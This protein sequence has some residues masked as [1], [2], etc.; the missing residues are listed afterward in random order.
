MW[1]LCKISRRR[2][3]G[4]AE[5]DLIIS[6][7]LESR[8]VTT[9]QVSV[10]DRQGH[11]ITSLKILGLVPD[12]S[13]AHVHDVS[14]RPGGIIAVAAVYVSKEGPSQVRPASTLL[15][16]DFEGRLVSFLAL[17][18]WRDIDRLEVDEQSNIWTL[19]SNSS[20]VK[21]ASMLVEYTSQGAVAKELVPRSLFPLHADEIQGNSAIGFVHMGYDADGL[22]FWLPGSTDFVT[23]PPKRTPPVTMKTGMPKEEPIESPISLV[24][25]SSGSLI[26]EFREG[27]R[28]QP[29]YYRWSPSTE[30]WVRFKPGVCDGGW[31]IG[32]AG[33]EEVY[34]GHEGADICLFAAQ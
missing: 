14:A 34:L 25:E 17:A 24:R 32:T 9:S 13:F 28:P 3:G 1:G 30:S 12:A 22:W 19:L 2:G 16:F 4:N 6:W 21:S 10:S 29:S 31:L 15:L 8:D 7:Q 33:N 27:V 18:P 20:E 23:V 26:G 11:E 5:N